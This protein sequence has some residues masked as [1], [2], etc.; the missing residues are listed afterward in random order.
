MSL[1]A[2]YPFPWSFEAPPP[3]PSRSTTLPRVAL[4]GSLDPTTGIFYRTPEHP[5]LRTAQACE[6]C[7]TRK[8]K[9]SGDHPSC[10][11]CLA[12]G[13]TCEYA[14]EG[15]IRGLNKTRSRGS[16]SDSPVLSSLHHA[17]RAVDRPPLKLEPL[18]SCLPLSLPRKH[19]APTERRLTVSTSFEHGYGLDATYPPSH[20][21][22]AYMSST[23]LPNPAPSFPCNS[24]PSMA[25]TASSPPYS[26]ASH[27]TLDGYGAPSSDPSQWTTAEQSYSPLP[28]PQ[29]S[30]TPASSYSDL[31]SSGSQNSIAAPHPQY[32][33][34]SLSYQTPHYAESE[35]TPS[36]SSAA[37]SLLYDES[38]NSTSASR[39]WGFDPPFA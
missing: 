11:R 33:P 8:A 14:K 29:Y 38:V 27:C 28:Y 21:R 34:Q 30:L 23:S 12:R 26:A 20:V 35:C 5:R 13:L 37:S 17:R 9:C 22:S 6:K 24:S 16:P 2:D 31:R 36:P 3:P 4:A 18:S 15:R 19:P 32:P 25:Y 39:R 10:A 1:Y 7:R